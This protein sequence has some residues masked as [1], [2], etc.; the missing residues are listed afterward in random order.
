MFRTR[1]EGRKPHT[2]LAAPS[3]KHPPKKSRQLRRL[4]SAMLLHGRGV[5]SHAEK[6]CKVALYFQSCYY[7]RDGVRSHAEKV[8]KVA[9]YF[10]SCYY[11]RDGVRSHAEK[12]CKVALYF[13]PCY[14]RNSSFNVTYSLSLLGCRIEDKRDGGMPTSCF[15]N[16]SMLWIKAEQLM[17][18]GVSTESTINVKYI[19]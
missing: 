12:V 3:L 2:E 16:A 14:S 17:L 7:M 13:Q 6:V 1:G 18:T 11:M 19:V 5:R 15:M 10:L 8:C 9:L 4:L